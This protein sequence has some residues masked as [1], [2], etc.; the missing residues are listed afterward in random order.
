MRKRINSDVLSQSFCPPSFL[1]TLILHHLLPTSH[2]SLPPNSSFPLPHFSF[3]SSHPSSPPLLSHTL[4]HPFPPLF[5]NPS[6]FFP[7]KVPCSREDVFS[8]KAISM[9]EKRRLM[10]FLT[11]CVDFE[12]HPEE[13]QGKAWALGCI[14]PPT[15]SSTSTRNHPVFGVSAVERPLPKPGPLYCT[16]DCHGG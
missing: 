13:Y 16:H 3:P 8:S 15:T 14:T 9:V 1:S 5:S 12:K 11:F 2:P 4:V 7:P 10:K 6:S